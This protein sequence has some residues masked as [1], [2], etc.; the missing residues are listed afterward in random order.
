M[1]KLNTKIL[2]L[3]LATAP[4]AI[5][6]IA[7]AGGSITSRHYVPNRPSHIKPPVVIRSGSPGDPNVLVHV[8]P[9]LVQ[10]RLYNIRGILGN[11]CVDTDEHMT[12]SDEEREA[13]RKVAEG[14][15]ASLRA[16]I[17]PMET[18]AMAQVPL[19]QAAAARAE[20][21]ADVDN[22]WKDICQAQANHTRQPVA[23]NTN[24]GLRV[25]PE[26]AVGSEIASD[27]EYLE[28]K[29]ARV[30]P[31][32]RN[33]PE[34][35]EEQEEVAPSRGLASVQQEAMR[36]QQLK[37]QQIQQAQQLKQAVSNNQRNPNLA[38]DEE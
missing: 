9:R 17:P 38:P 4:F 2:A 18:A 3:L 25:Y 1:H 6:A 27:E 35:E 13:A 20:L 21:T 5:P 14:D 32:Q 7:E 29:M 16:Q 37:A 19:P 23:Y 15:C 30:R 10:G 8:E 12:W 31:Q 36:R 26:N 24:R 34:V 22:F 28:H 11:L 33:Q